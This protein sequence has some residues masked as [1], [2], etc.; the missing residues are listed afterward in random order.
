MNMLVCDVNIARF[1]KINKH[2]ISDGSILSDSYDESD[3]S[4]EEN[5]NV[6]TGC[7]ENEPQYTEFDLKEMKTT[8]S[9]SDG[10]SEEE[11]GSS[12]LE[13]LH[14]YTCEKYVITFSMA[15]EE[16]KCCRESASLLSESEK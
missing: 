13:N 5:E 7:Y 15:F 16:C 9:G 10:C 12:R 2:V 1:K 6:L 4:S 3:I 8:D 14:W 11:F